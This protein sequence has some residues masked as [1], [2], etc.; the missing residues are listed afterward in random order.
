MEQLDTFIKEIIETKNLPGL[1]EEA[2]AQ[3]LEEMRRRLLDMIDRALIE[4][5]PDDK[6]EE[7]STLLDEDNIED[8]SLQTFVAQSGID[9]KSV[10]AKTM[11]A[12]RALYL[13]TPRERS[14]E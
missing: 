3:L 14:V 7:L 4:A 13:E 10:T 8:T 11:L 2:K 1:T 6:V 5:L 12:F 9:V